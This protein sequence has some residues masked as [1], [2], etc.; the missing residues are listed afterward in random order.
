MRTLARITTTTPQAIIFLVDQSGS[1]SEKI[2][3]D[4]H[5]MSKAE[6]VSSVINM[7]LEE[8]LARCNSFG[9]I[10]NYFVISVL[11]YGGDGVNS[12]L[13]GDGFVRASQLSGEF[14]ERRE[15][16][17]VHQV[18]GRKVLTSSSR[19]IWVVPRCEGE[20]PM[21]AAYDRSYDILSAW[22]PAFR[23]THTPQPLVINITDGEATDA[24]MP[25]LRHSS[26]RLKSLS[27]LEGETILMNIHISCVASGSQLFPN[28]ELSP[29]N[30]CLVARRLFAL[31]SVM[32]ESYNHEIASI[33]GDTP[34]YRAFACNTQITD[35]LKLLDISSTSVQ[36][37]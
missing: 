9:V 25:K 16:T 5:L 3:W 11:G 6:A 24:P 4:G 14:V 31:S 15:I 32:P 23:N 18:G 10:K 28:A 21:C 27:T 29:E 7:V 33:S 30:E 20:S 34:P 36:F 8:I 35:L 22:I 26:G 13:S 2:L 17:N 12:L 1:M 37:S 19:R